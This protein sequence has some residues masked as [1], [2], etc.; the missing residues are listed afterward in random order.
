MRALLLRYE[1]V[2]RFILAGGIGTGVYTAVTA[3]LILSGLTPDRVI[4]SAWA[5]LASLPVSFI[6]HRLITYRDTEYAP[7]QWGRFAVVSLGTLGLNTGLML[8][9]RALG[10]PFWIAIGFGWFAGPAATYVL[11]ALWVFRTRKFLALDR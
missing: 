11:N 1:R 7:V 2:I 5:T 3:G 4:A 8:A 6:A 10:W 9:S